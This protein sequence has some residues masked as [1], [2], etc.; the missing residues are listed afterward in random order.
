MAMMAYK[1]IGVFD[2]SEEDWATYVERVKLY[3]AANKITDVRQK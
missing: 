3:L 2:S 1:S